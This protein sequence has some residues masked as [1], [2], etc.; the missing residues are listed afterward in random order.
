MANDVRVTIKGN[1]MTIEIEMQKPKL[2]SSG[3]TKVVASTGGF[4][5][6]DARFKGHIVSVNLNATIP[7]RGI[8][9]EDEDDD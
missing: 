1:K 6:S 8:I 7:N 5:K 2:S 9:E 3:K 4:S